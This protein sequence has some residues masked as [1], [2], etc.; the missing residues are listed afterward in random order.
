MKAAYLIH[1][2]TIEIR[3]VAVPQPGP[4][5]VLVRVRAVGVCGSDVHYYLEGRIG[6]SIATEPHIM[7]HE[8]AG[9]IA[10]L[11]AGVTGLRVGQLV[12]VEP[13]IS[14]GHC[15]LCREGHPTSAC[16]SAS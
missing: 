11:G 16:T 5:Q 4:G 8:F 6:D 15:E 13:A 3:E 7:G 12:A 9:E 10:A 1:P 14:C 2:K